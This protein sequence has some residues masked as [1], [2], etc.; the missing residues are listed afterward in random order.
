M[1]FEHKKS[2]EYLNQISNN[3]NEKTALI[4]ES[5][6]EQSLPYKNLTRTILEIGIGGA[7]SLDKIKNELP[8]DVDLIAADLIPE[9]ARLA[10][11]KHG[12][13]AVATDIGS[14]PF[15]T[16]SLS[17]VNASAVLHEVSSYGTRNDG[18][19]TIYGI[20]A[21][22]QSLREIKRVLLPD[23][24]LSYRDISAPLHNLFE[25]KNVTYYRRSWDAFIRW[26]LPDFI[27]SR[28]HPY[29]SSEIEMRKNNNGLT[30]KGPVGLHRELQRHYIMFRDYTRNIM[31]ERFGILLHQLDW[32]NEE[33]GLKRG[34]LSITNPRI[35]RFLT[36]INSAKY[37]SEKDNDVY[38]MNSDD[39]DLLYD[40]V[41]EYYFEMFS[42][43]EDSEL[44]DL[45]EQWK[46]RE[47]GEHYIYATPTEIV[48]M[49]YDKK[50]E[51]CNVLFPAKLA[52]VKLMPRHYYNRYLQQVIDEPEFDGK[53]I[54][55]LRKINVNKAKEL[56]Y[57]FAQ[58]VDANKI[59]DFNYLNE[60]LE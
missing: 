42:N 6:R 33:N 29:E 10:K 43:N 8:S 28:F 22:R 19:T 15:K 40:K 38:E 30:L 46:L 45:F 57:T 13:N 50:D 56:S 52:D 54:L 5:L 47:G 9:I 39:L 37:Q 1:S 35:R 12:I 31:G 14:L 34:V 17:A 11:D 20:D 53:I 26:F 7:E 21:V 44:K 51:L 59:I 3:C 25:E 32:L 55:G 4:I 49:T 60:N 24:L 58:G 18:I 2:P 36:E 16:E 48:A 41:I 23:G 27:N